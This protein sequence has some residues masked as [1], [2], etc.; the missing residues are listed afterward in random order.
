MFS[1][2]VS[3]IIIK[4]VP[5]SYELRPAKPSPLILPRSDA[6]IVLWVIGNSKDLPVRL[7]TTVIVCLLVSGWQKPR[8]ST[9]KSRREKQKTWKNE[10]KK[11][12]AYIRLKALTYNVRYFVFK[13]SYTG[14]LAEHSALE[15]SALSA[16]WF[17]RTRTLFADIFLGPV[18][19]IQRRRFARTHCVGALESWR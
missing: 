3:V 11:A 16:K 18:H 19:K 8:R 9:Q 1:V 17:K 5:G 14:F 4:Y 2:N 10:N 12:C 6:L 13:I 15:T 7:S